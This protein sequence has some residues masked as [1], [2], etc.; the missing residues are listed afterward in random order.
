MD[1]V[2]TPDAAALASEVSFQ[3]QRGRGPGGQN[4]NKVASA[5]LLMWDYTNSQLLDAGQKA[6]VGQKLAALLNSRGE[7][8]LRSDEFRDQERNKA[9]A[10]EKL[11]ERIAAALFVPK[12]RRPTKP[13]R[14][15]RIRREETKIQRSRTKKLRG[16]PDW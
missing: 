5:V 14:A 12:K 2:T 4:V 13:T 11:E 9:R 1:R 8:Q 10:L 16:R 15:S 7:I 6:R 3:A